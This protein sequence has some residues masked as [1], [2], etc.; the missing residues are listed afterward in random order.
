MFR[1]E[2]PQAGRYRQL[3]QFGIEVFGSED[4]SIDA[5]VIGLGYS[6]YSELG[7]KDVTC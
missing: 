4:P 5:E 1:Y 7:I 6:F 3:H 2:R